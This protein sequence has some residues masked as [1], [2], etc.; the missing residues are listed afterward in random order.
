MATEGE[1]VQAVP[2][3]SSGS[4]LHK[5]DLCTSYAPTTRSLARQVATLE[6]PPRHA[7]GTLPRCRLLV[8]ASVTLV[9]M[10][11]L[12]AFRES[13]AYPFRRRN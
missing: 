5:I 13:T 10:F 12:V 7:H 11:A 1:M 6:T 9:R 3:E 8:V 4:H 2:L